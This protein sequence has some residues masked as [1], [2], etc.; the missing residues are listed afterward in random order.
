[1]SLSPTFP[2]SFIPRGEAAVLL[3]PASVE[4]FTL[5][6][7][8]SFNTAIPTWKDGTVMSVTAKEYLDGL[9]WFLANPAEHTEWP[10]DTALAA[11][12]DLYLLARPLRDRIKAIL[13]AFRLT[14]DLRL[15]DGVVKWLDI[16]KGKL[17]VGYRNHDPSVVTWDASPFRCWVV[18][19]SGFPTTIYGTDLTPMN[20]VKWH[21]TIAEVTYALFLNLG[22]TSPAG[23]NYTTEYNF[24]LDYLTNDFVPKWSGGGTAD[25]R[26]TY[27]GVRRTPNYSTPHHRAGA[28][29]W[30]IVINGGEMH[31]S[32][33]STNLAWFMWK[34]T[35]NV[36]AFD[37]FNLYTGWW[38]DIDSVTAEDPTYGTCRLWPHTCPSQGSGSNYAQPATYVAYT[39][40]DLLTTYL[41]GAHSRVGASLMTE[42][43]NTHKGFFFLPG[44]P[45]VGGAFDTL[46][47]YGDIAG[48]VPVGGMTNN[49]KSGIAQIDG[50]LNQTFTVF[51][52]ETG[53]TVLEDA[54]TILLAKSFG[55][56]KA[57]PKDPHI[58]AAFMLKYALAET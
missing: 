58:N 43:A 19:H 7:D 44:T 29:E 42:I 37:E 12:D 8:G 53:D 39:P 23:Y 28:G 49:P 41:E 17:A 2:Y 48:E 3:P 47:S 56:G 50:T 6:G 15:L 14:G 21:A 30:P 20:E 34:L 35:G 54:A 45:W 16:S 22:N 24:W 11:R 55:G 51:P 1:M 26:D 27:R 33:S 52:F 36:N 32:V 9:I 13:L 18:A 40:M 4:L 25:W 10:T 57:T 5:A 31:S 46:I 38:L